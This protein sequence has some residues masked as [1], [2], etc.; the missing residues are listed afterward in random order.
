MKNKRSLLCDECGAVMMEYIIVIVLVAGV[1]MIFMNKEFFSFE[2]A[3]F[4]ALGT[5]IV[6]MYERVVAG[7]A[8]PIP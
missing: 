5:P 6:E 7:I 1:L 3:S 4:G 2:T 8:L